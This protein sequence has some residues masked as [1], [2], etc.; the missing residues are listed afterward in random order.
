MARERGLDDR[1][2]RLRTR[3]G[4]AARARARQLEGRGEGRGRAGLS[5]AAREGPH[6][7]PRLRRAGSHVARDRAAR[8]SAAGRR[9]SRRT[10]RPNWCSTGR[11]STPRPAARWAISGALYSPTTGEKVADVET[12]VRRR[13]GLTVHRITTLRADPRGRCAARRGRSAGARFHACA[14]TP[15]RTCCTPRC[16][17][18]WART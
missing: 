9:A 7:V 1:P 10:R 8:G 15:P 6:A 3:D 16:G 2:R 14:T 12:R 4:A 18:C 17:R 13:P 5:E 11:R